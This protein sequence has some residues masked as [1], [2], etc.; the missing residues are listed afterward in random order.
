MTDIDQKGR[1]AGHRVSQIWKV[2]ALGTGIFFQNSYISLWILTEIS[3]KQYDTG[4][5]AFGWEYGPWH[6]PD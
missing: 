3:T 4:R 6:L 5:C 2:I 1:S